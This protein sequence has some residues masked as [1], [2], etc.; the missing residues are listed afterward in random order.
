MHV[1]PGLLSVL[2]AG[3]VQFTERALFTKRAQC[4]FSLFTERSQCMFC[5][6]Y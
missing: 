6:V 2:S 4:R 1:W 5:P 3:L